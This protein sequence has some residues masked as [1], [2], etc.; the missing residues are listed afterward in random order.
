M[1]MNWLDK[2]IASVAPRTA[3]RRLG[4]RLALE[5]LRSYDAAKAGRRTD[6]WITSGQS[7]NAEIGPAAARIRARARELVRNNPHASRAVSIVASNVVGVG[8]KPRLTEEDRSSNPGALDAFAEWMQQ[9]DPEGQLNWCAQQKLMMRTIFESGEALILWNR[10]RT[11][12]RLTVPLQCRILE[13]D[14]LDTSRDAT[15]RN[16]SGQIIQG[17]E[18][19]AMGERV[20]YW[21][22]P[23][24]PGDTFQFS[25]SRFESVRVP[26]DRVDHVFDPLRP[27]QVRGVPWMASVALRLRDVD[28][29]NEAEV[30]RRKIQACLAGFV[31]TVD[32]EAV[33]SGSSTTNAAGDRI[34]TFAPGTM[35]YLEPGQDVRF[36]SPEASADYEGTLSVQLH[37]VAAGTGVTYE[38]MTGDL[39]K[40]NFTS[41]RVGKLAFYALVD[42]WQELMFIPQVCERAWR[43]VGMIATARNRALDPWPVPQWGKPGRPYIDPREVRA[44][45]DEIRAGLTTLPKEI[46]AKGGDPVKALEEIAATNALLDQLEVT[47]DSD[48]RQA[49]RTGAAAQD[50]GT[51]DGEDESEDEDEDAA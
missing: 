3:A 24:H 15:S 51:D 33:V 18:F 40:V 11:E 29:T 31:V 23:E 7:A 44:K 4:A 21:L 37:A 6:G 34:E 10:R 17:I 5:Q 16:S 49:G 35:Q 50:E 30:V 9:S 2:A 8:V 45:I 41:M 12:T 19:N 26:A 25:R 28:D 43:R 39:A 14:F 20:A 48:P 38:D 22:Y 27:G 46:A 42:Q 36:T 13:P 1:D 47:L 32:P